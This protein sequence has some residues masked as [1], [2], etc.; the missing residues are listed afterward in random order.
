MVN[1]K[2]IGNGNV[3]SV[4]YN[5]ENGRQWP[6]MDTEYIDFD[7]GKAI[8]PDEQLGNGKV[9]LWMMLRLLI[10]ITKEKKSYQSIKLLFFNLLLNVLYIILIYNNNKTE[11]WWWKIVENR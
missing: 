7:I 1:V 4:H 8:V 11:K 6:E 5:D 3:S 10:I 2:L 9:L